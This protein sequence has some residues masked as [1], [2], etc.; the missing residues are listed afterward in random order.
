[1]TFSDMMLKQMNVVEGQSAAQYV[2]L[3]S[4]DHMGQQSMIFAELTQWSKT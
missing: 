2:D 1:M 4:W 3:L